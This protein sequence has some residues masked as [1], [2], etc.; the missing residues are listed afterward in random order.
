[1][2]VLYPFYEFFQKAPLPADQGTTTVTLDLEYLISIMDTEEILRWAHLGWQIVA[3]LVTIVVI[4][5]TAYKAA[6]TLFAIAVHLFFPMPNFKKYGQWAVVTGA[7]DGI[8]KAYAMELANAGMD[9]VLIS[10]TLSKLEAVA[11]EIEETYSVKT[12]VIAADFTR[13]DIYQMIEKELAG[14]DVGVLVNNVGMSYPYPEYFLEL[15][16]GDK[17]SMDLV[18][19]NVV[20][21]VQ[22]TRLVMPRMTEK[23]KGVVIN[24][25]SISAESIVPL[26]SLYGATKAFVAH[27]SENLHA[28]YSKMGVHVHLVIPGYVATQMSGIR[29]ASLSVP[30]PKAFVIS[31]LRS[32][33]WLARTGGYWFHVILITLS[34]TVHFYFPRLMA[35]VMLLTLGPLRQRAL[36]KRKVQ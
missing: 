28:E 10:R 11:K 25:A 20:S 15:P 8:G 3:S 34:D 32:V 17:I 9:V 6:Q 33:G 13:T 19:C 27:F 23:R 29:K 22:M 2:G 35:M 7:A 26:L 14:L 24:L 18:N 21:L 31:D 36:R 1:M 30:S 16:E 12:K 5:V 4:L